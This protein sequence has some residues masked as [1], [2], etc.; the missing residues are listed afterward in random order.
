MQRSGK[1]LQITCSINT[2]NKRAGNLAAHG[3]FFFLI[4]VELFLG[5]VSAGKTYLQFHKNVNREA[6][7]TLQITFRKYISLLRQQQAYTEMNRNQL[8]QS[9]HYQNCLKQCLLIVTSSPSCSGDP[10]REPGHSSRGR[11]VANIK[12]SSGYVQRS[13]A[14]N[15]SSHPCL[16]RVRFLFNNTPGLKRAGDNWNST[17]GPR[18]KSPRN[19]GSIIAGAPWR[20]ACS[21]ADVIGLLWLLFLPPLWGPY[22]GPALELPWDLMMSPTVGCELHGILGTFSARIPLANEL[23]TPRVL[24]L[25][26]D[27]YHPV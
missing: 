18:T 2:T 4:D 13:A 21:S 20:M 22:I 27:M 8:L 15:T 19:P 10:V 12:L 3:N 11:P 16:E 24:C 1:V 9:Q 14:K 7:F 23:F 26:S 17:G 25:V 6:G 5:F